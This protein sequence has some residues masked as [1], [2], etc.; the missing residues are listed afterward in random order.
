MKETTEVQG[1]K[2]PG[3]LSSWM[4]NLEER[5]VLAAAALV[6]ASIEGQGEINLLSVPFFL[7]R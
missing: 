1:R 2:G 3:K 7:C 5:D 4:G 6:G